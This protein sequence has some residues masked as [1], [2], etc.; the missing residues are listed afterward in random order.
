MDAAELQKLIPELHALIARFEAAAPGR[1][2]TVD[3]HL[4]GSISDVG[5]CDQCLG[6][7]YKDI[8]ILYE[9]LTLRSIRCLFGLSTSCL[10]YS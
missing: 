4:V 7:L 5:G 8:E 6:H 10:S 3:G 9:V 2:F 1:H